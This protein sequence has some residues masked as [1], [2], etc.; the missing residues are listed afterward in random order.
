[1]MIFSR[2]RAKFFSFWFG[3]SR[4]QQGVQSPICPPLLPSPPRP[5]YA[6]VRLLVC[7]LG[8][9]RK[10]L[11]TRAPDSFP[12]FVRGTVSF[13]QSVS[14]SQVPE[15]DNIVTVV[16]TSSAAG[17]IFPCS[18]KF[19]VSFRYACKCMWNISVVGYKVS[20]SYY[21]RWFLYIFAASRNLVMASLSKPFFA[22][23]NPPP[24]GC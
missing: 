3:E 10:F 18:R 2:Y 4:V 13:A 21:E 5:A 20:L 15:S 6:F 16:A 14:H 17:K 8:S 1:M 7:H 22:R 24:R 11:R 12:N 19:K 23:G 9:C